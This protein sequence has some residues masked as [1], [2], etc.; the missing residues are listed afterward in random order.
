MGLEKDKD[1]RELWQP[2]KWTAIGSRMGR[3]D[4]EARMDL[5]AGRRGRS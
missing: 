5:V 2:V 1:V 3:T 4:R